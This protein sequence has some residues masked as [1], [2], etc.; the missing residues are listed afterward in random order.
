MLFEKYDWS[1]RDLVQNALQKSEEKHKQRKK[2]EEEEEEEKKKASH[3]VKFNMEVVYHDDKS[4]LSVSHDD[5]EEYVT[6]ITI[7]MYSPL[8]REEEEE[9]EG[10][11]E[12]EDE[13]E[14]EEEG[15]RAGSRLSAKSAP[16]RWAGT[17]LIQCDVYYVLTYSL[18]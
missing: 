7:N 13:D 3:E 8:I 15:S 14:D 10:E 12:E 5:N 9:D 4:K 17:S 11:D 6:H 2:K 18:T 1:Y 16:H